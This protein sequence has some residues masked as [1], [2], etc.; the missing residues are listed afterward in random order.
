MPGS[1]NP[2]A[3]GLL[4]SGKHQSGNVLAAGST[5]LGPRYDRW[6]PSD[7]AAAGAAYFTR[8]VTVFAADQGA[9][10]MMLFDGDYDADFRQFTNTSRHAQFD[11]DIPEDFYAYGGFKTLTRVSAMLMVQSQR[12]SELRIS[13][14]DALGPQWNQFGANN[15]PAQVTFD[16]PPVLS[17]DAF[18]TGVEFLSQDQIYIYIEQDVIVDFSDYWANYHATFSYWI[19]LKVVDG[20]VKSQVQRWECWV[21]GGAFTSVVEAILKPNVELAAIQLERAVDQ[22]LSHIPPNVVSIYY[23][24]GR[25]LEQVQGIFGAD[26]PDD[27]TIIFEF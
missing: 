5:Y 26:N 3:V 16:G 18:P 1:Q 23:L 12:R 15:L 25:Q 9:A 11:A 24:P 10:I 8:S 6:W 4:Y 17:W 20:A 21:E 7:M 22:A 2:G 14:R 13:C 27:T 19:Y